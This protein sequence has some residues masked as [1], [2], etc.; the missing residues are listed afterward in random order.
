MSTK[1]G[2]VLWT[3]ERT[4]IV[5]ERKP[6]MVGVGTM[7]VGDGLGDRG[8]G[9]PTGIIVESV[10]LKSDRHHLAWHFVDTSLS[11]SENGEYTG[12]PN[13]EDVHWVP[14]GIIIDEIPA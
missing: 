9:R 6:H 10:A 13:A 8:L 1:D 2:R 5:Y 14:L 3:D 12:Y 11:G 7:R 4:G